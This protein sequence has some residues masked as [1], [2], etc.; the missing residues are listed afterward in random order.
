M[1]DVTPHRSEVGINPVAHR[2]PLR[3]YYE[4]TD[5]AGVVYYANYLKFA[6]RARSEMLHAAGLDQ[7]RIRDEDDVVFAVR[8]CNADYRRPAR[9]GETVVVETV[10]DKVG[11]ASIGLC[12]RV[13][14]D[15]EVLVE[16]I[17]TLVCMHGDGRAT[18]IPAKVRETLSAMAVP[19]KEV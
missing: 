13:V 16:M 1:D 18:R 15:G 9:L 12:Q 11:G 17:V 6:E 3:V 10:V 8:A 5:A 7:I 14:R 2:W 19:T 4:D